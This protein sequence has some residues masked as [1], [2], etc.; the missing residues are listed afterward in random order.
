[1]LRKIS[2]LKTSR[3]AALFILLISVIT[4][5]GS[6]PERTPPPINLNKMAEIPGFSEIRYYG[7]ESSWIDEIFLSGTNEEIASL[8]SG[9]IGR[10]HNYLTVSGGGANGAFGAGL[11][12]GWTEA[13]TRPEFTVVT[14][15]STGALIA[16]FAFLGPAYDETLNELYTTLS[17]EDLIKPRGVLKA[18]TSDAAASTELLQVKI[19]QYIDQD[20]VDAIAA[21]YRRGRH[22]VIGTTDIDAGWTVHWFIGRIANTDNPKRI[23]LIR[24]VLLASAP[25]PGAL[26]PVFF[27]VE[28]GGQH[29]DEMHVDGGAINQVFLYSYDFDWNFVSERLAIKGKPNI[30]SIRNSRLS[31]KREIVEPKLL[32]IADRSISL[33]IQ[34]QGLGDLFLMALLAERDNLNFYLSY[35]PDDFD[36]EEKEMFD[37]VYINALFDLGYRIAKE[38]NPWLDALKEIEKY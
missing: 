17:T 23:D 27:D 31:P 25:I 32:S 15:I 29:F 38:G 20:I 19:A 11:L 8:Y 1:M 12:V 2:Y 33:L 10:E 18:L 5:C 22:L 4:G 35:I 21:E 7:D 13:G 9:V 37:L 24:K 14:G 16:P 34:S 6:V 3:F 36:M 26:P 30:Y 28:Y